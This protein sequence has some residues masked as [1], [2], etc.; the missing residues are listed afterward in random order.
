MLAFKEFAGLGRFWIKPACWVQAWHG[1]HNAALAS[2]WGP[3]SNNQ[4]QEAAGAKRPKHFSC[5]GLVP[6]EED[7]CA[8]QFAPDSSQQT[9]AGT[10]SPQ[11]ATMHA[12]TDKLRPH[13]SRV[14]QWEQGASMVP[15]HMQLA[16]SSRAFSTASAAPG[17]D[18]AAAKSQDIKS[19]LRTLYKLIHPDLFPDNTEA[20]VNA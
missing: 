2:A 12:S 15:R 20:K 10:S 16:G 14:V 11:R 8:H 17:S 18:S 4:G 9:A 1:Q 6:A 3:D 13:A 7:V 5:A 19:G